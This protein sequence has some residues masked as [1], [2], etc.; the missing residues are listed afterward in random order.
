[1]PD[2]VEAEVKVEDAYEDSSQAS[3]EL[4]DKIS[5]GLT[6][7]YPDEDDPTPEPDPAEPAESEESTPE[8]KDE[9]KSEPADDDDTTPENESDPA[10][11][12]PNPESKSESESESEP[13]KPAI[14]DNYYRAAIHQGWEPGQISKLYETDPEGTLKFLEKCYN[15]VNSMSQQFAQLGRKAKEM[16]PAPDTEG[17]EQKPKAFDPEAFKKAY[18]EDPAA[19]M[20]SMFEAMQ[21][22]PQQQPE[23]TP[24]QQSQQTAK[25]E[26]QE[27][28]SV[29]EQLNGF[30]N[31]DDLKPFGDFYGASGKLDWGDLTPGQYA[32]RQAVVN[33]ADEILAGAE[34]LQTG[35]TVREAVEKAHLEVTAP[36]LEK[37][38]RQ[39]IIKKVTKK[40]KG[41]TLRPT[42]KEEKPPKKGGK[43]SD[44]EVVANIDSR[45]AELR[46]KG[47]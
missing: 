28:L 20:V 9:L 19:A 22:Q 32:N 25:N 27:R 6:T 26:M 23:Q 18:D 46:E 30:F 40:A 31:A 41:V 24:V 21:Q 34:L 29:V 47:L 39:D 11:D 44:G 13:E 42:R 10:G 8:P 35:M 45:L 15:D 38:V 1:M 5:E 43:L 17:S 7:L 4:L 16:Q 37:I 33:L 14:P 12:D 36:M 2:P 3:P